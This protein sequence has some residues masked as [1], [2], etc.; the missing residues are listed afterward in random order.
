M[1]YNGWTNYETW[2]VSLWIDNEEGSYRH[3]RSQAEEVYRDAEPRS[4]LTRKEVASHKLADMLKEEVCDGNPLVGASMYA[5]LL[6]AALSEVNWDE[7]A[8][9]WIDEA[10]ADLHSTDE[11]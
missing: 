9:N 7:I 2:N 4:I 8:G 10:T 11:E 5:D 1:S 6:G 3:W